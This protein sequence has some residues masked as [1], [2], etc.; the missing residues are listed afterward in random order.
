MAFSTLTGHPEMLPRLE[1]SM[2]YYYYN[3]LSPYYFFQDQKKEKK[4]TKEG[5]EVTQ[6]REMKKATS[7]LAVTLAFPVPSSPHLLYLLEL[8]Q[9]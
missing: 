6:F 2:V 7:I 1:R 8:E 5:L 9:K 4:K 3:L